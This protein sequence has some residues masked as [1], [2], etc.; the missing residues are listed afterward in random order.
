M[1]VIF[2][3]TIKA[4]GIGGWYIELKDTEDGRVAICKDLQ[5][6]EE[7]IEEL[8][9]DYGGHI[10]EV[11]WNQDTDVTPM[12]LDE[13]RLQ[14]AAIREKIEEEKGEFITPTGIIKDEK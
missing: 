12:M 8:G 13:I 10:D 7:K 5:E 9:A 4:D 2:E 6:Y 14:M 11:R 1:A 3:S